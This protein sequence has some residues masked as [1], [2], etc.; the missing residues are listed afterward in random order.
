MRDCITSSKECD[1]INKNHYKYTISSDTNPYSEKKIPKQRCLRILIYQLFENNYALI[2]P[3]N[4]RGIS[5]LAT[6]EVILFKITTPETTNF[7]T[8][9]V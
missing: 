9:K 5:I 4:A 1:G 8:F 6:G 7:A 3:L 2:L